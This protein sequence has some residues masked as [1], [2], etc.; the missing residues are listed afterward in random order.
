MVGIPKGSFL[1][2][3]T[4]FLLPRNVSA[5]EENHMKRDPYAWK[6]KAGDGSPGRKLSA[7]E[8]P[9]MCRK[10]DFRS[11]PIRGILYQADPNR[12]LNIIQPRL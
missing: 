5:T 4:P 3:L 1:K 9:G 2:S 7:L 11:L 12:V 8:T 10:G 6:T